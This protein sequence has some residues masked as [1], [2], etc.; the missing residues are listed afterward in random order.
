M[1]YS[2]NESKRVWQ[3]HLVI[4]LQLFQTKGK[5]K[6][7]EPGGEPEPA[8][9]RWA[10]KTASEHTTCA[11]SIHYRQTWCTAHRQEEESSRGSILL[12]HSASPA[13]TTP[14]G[15]GSPE[16]LH[17]AVTHESVSITTVVVLG[18]V[19]VAVIVRVVTVRVW[20]GEWSAQVAPTCEVTSYWFPKSS[21]TVASS[22]SSARVRERDEGM[23][24]RSL[25]RCQTGFRDYSNL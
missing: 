23:K 11:Q 6:R 19:R 8:S 25:L 12:P 22:S 15:S 13:R 2:P 24:G 3:C 5:R 9:K 21:S 17:S 18:T 1:F 7:H 20:L 4:G 10:H 14:L 16:T